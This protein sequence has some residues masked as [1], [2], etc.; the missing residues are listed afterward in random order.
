MSLVVGFVFDAIACVAIG[1]KGRV[2]WR[3]LGVGIGNDDLWYFFAMV[4]GLRGLVER[5]ENTFVISFESLEAIAVS[6]NNLIGNIGKDEHIIVDANVS[7]LGHPF[8][9]CLHDDVFAA[10]IA[11]LLKVALHDGRPWHGHVIGVEFLV[12]ADAE[13][14]G[15]G[16]A[17]FG[18]T[19]AQSSPEQVGSGGLALAAD[20]ADRDHFARWVA[21]AR[22]M[23]NR[24]NIV[25][26]I[27]YFLWCEGAEEFLDSFHGLIIARI[28]IVTGQ[29][30]IIKRIC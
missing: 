14:G 26:G 17:D 22:G 28:G 11:H 15:T 12:L 7:P 4:R 18:A 5:F 25:V 19:R 1:R 24:L 30:H 9:R 20:D 3:I 16:L 13:V 6:C 21:V 29:R 27:D 10:R 2:A 8:G 23:A